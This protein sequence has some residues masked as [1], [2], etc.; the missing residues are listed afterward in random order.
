EQRR[1]YD[2]VLERVQA[3][4][5]VEAAAFAGNHPLDPGFANSFYVVGRR[6]EAK[7]WP[8][9]SIRRVD[10]GYFGTMRVPLVSGR[11]LRPADG[12]SAAPVLL[13][14]EQAARRFFQ[15]R[16]PLGQ[17]IAFWGAD[18]TIVG[19]VSDERF[20]GLAADP[21][22]A[23]YAPLAQCPS[24]NGA[25]SLLVRAQG[26]PAA[27]A[28][29]V[30]AAIRQVDP[31]LAVFGVEPLETTLAESIAKQR[32]TMLLVTVFAGLALLLALVGVYGILSYIVAQRT[33]EIGIRMAMGAAPRNV[34]RLIVLQGT[35]LAL[36]GLALGLAGALLMTRFLRTLL[37]VV[38]ATDPATFAAVLAA[39]F[40]A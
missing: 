21:P 23:V 10:P 13:I 24:A 17:Q 31:E 39:V 25:G 30:R 26:D 12:A 14:N 33:S 35:R 32:F 2:A 5:G 18:R 22:P 29:A 7:D 9:I 4:P 37:F 38:G 11:L 19:I 1:F 28:P 27:L 16:D 40:A 36:C 8:E 6:E 20:H 34:V 15:G 3:L